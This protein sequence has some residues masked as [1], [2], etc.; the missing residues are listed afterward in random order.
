M[1][2]I[3]DLLK[4]GWHINEFRMHAKS[5][6]VYRLP[7]HLPDEQM[8]YFKANDNIDDVLDRDGSKKTRLTAWFEANRKYQAACNI[9]YQSFPRT[10]VYNDKRR[11]G[12]QESRV[13]LLLAECTLHLLPRVR[14]S[15]SELFSLLLQVQHHS[16]TCVQ[17]MPSSILPLSRPALH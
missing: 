12:L 14:D 8:V 2:V 1:H 10:W 17:S 15:I 9:T 16:S 7:V 5:P 4:P 11:S 13:L 3:L 6:T